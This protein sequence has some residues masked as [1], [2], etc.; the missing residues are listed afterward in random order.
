[1]TPMMTID[2]FEKDLPAS[3]SGSESRLIREFVHLSAHP[4]LSPR[5]IERQLLTSLTLALH[6]GQTAC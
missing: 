4:T 6:R 5:A 3:L 1:M 2:E